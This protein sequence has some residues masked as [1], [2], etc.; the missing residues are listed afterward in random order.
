MEEVFKTPLY[1]SKSTLISKYSITSKVLHSKS[2]LSESTEVLS[3]KCTSIKS[4]ST[5]FRQ[6]SKLA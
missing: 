5:F 2:Y 3:A 1:L 6:Q 4:K